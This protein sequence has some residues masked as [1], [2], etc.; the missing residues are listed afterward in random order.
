[1]LLSLLRHGTADANAWDHGRRLTAVGRAEVEL[2]AGGLVRAGFRPGII[3]A[4]PLL[5]AQETAR[6]VAHH[7]PEV[8]L[9]TQE[10][11]AAGSAESLM[12]IAA[13]QQDPMLVGH[14]PT[15]GMLAA[16]LMGAPMNALPMERAGIAV[17]EVDRLPATRPAR[18]LL[19]SSPKWAGG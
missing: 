18:L 14:E 2:I 4:S 1:M 15:L 5:R 9:V 19:W 3:L 16:R 10:L 6:I 12:W 8:P 17:F 13:D 7:F 11:L